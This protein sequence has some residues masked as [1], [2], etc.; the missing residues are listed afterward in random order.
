MGESYLASTVPT[1]EIIGNTGHQPGL[2]HAQQ[3]ADSG[4]LVNVVGKR[5]SN[6]T[7]TEAQSGGWQE[8]TGPNPLASNL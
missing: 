5:R 4:N 1:T 2:K 3:K 7:D 8:P 6:R